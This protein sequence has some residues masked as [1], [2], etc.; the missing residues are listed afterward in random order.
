MNGRL[1]VDSQLQ[2]FLDRTRHH[3]VKI[4]RS[5]VGVIE[6]RNSDYITYH[7]EKCHDHCRTRLLS[8]GPQMTIPQSP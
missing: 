3:Y 4:A 1:S 5:D 8:A 7:A 2:K 6:P